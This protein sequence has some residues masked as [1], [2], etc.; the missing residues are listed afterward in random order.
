MI[1]TIFYFV[2]TEQEYQAKRNSGEIKPYTI[3]FVRD[4]RA[5]WK[6]GIRYSGFTEDEI[7]QIIE[8]ETEDINAA[9]ELIN[10]TIEEINQQVSDE[11]D[12]L[13]DVVDGL[14]SEIQDKVE[15]LFADSQWIQNNQP[16][17]LV[18]PYD[19]SWDNNIQAYLQRVGL[20]D[21]N[22]DSIVTKWSTIR[23]SLNSIQSDVNSIT[24]TGGALD[25]L[26][27]QITQEV[28]D[29]GDAITNLGNTYARITDVDGVKD[30]IE[31][32]YS[33]LKSGS[34]ADKTYAEIVAAGKNGLS[35]AISDLRTSVDSLGSTYVAQS[36]LTSSV[37]SA[38]SGIINAASGTYANTSMFSKIDTNSDDIAAIAT[39]VTGDSSQSTVAAKLNGMTASLVTTAN[40]DSAMAGL[41]AQ[42]KNTVGDAIAAT[43]FAKANEQGSTITLDADQINLQGQ[44]N[45]ENAVGNWI[46]TKG[47]KV[48]DVDGEIKTVLEDGNAT[49]SGDVIANSLTAGPNSGMHIVTTGDEIQFLNGDAVLGKFVAEGDGLQMYILNEQGQLYKINFSNWSSTTSSGT[50]YTDQLYNISTNASYPYISERT[51]V[52]QKTINGEYYSNQAGTAQASYGTSTS[53]GEYLEKTG[54]TAAIV[55]DP[56]NGRSTLY[57]VS[58]YKDVYFVDGIKQNGPNIYGTISRT[59]GNYTRTYFIKGGTTTGE[60][61]SY[62][63]YVSNQSDRTINDYT[64]MVFNNQQYYFVYTF[65]GTASSKEDLAFTGGT[66]SYVQESS[67]GGS[68]VNYTPY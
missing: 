30:V 19:M 6:N 68:I 7:K 67:T 43:I 63:I 16:Q 18:V 36:S 25:L 60:I 35:S 32:M 24:E 20:W 48:S 53:T 28:T 47:L 34:G 12:R 56:G 61:S 5:I 15:D 27:S 62:Q 29:R 65:Y 10:H 64:S 26:Q 11:K 8:L 33:G 58:F 55:Q 54:S 57:L 2:D 9:I 13:D 21:Y 49:F 1:N 51:K 39:K 38:I 37:D 46:T 44:T 14:D 41:S 31:W 17:G 23:Q 3:V 4:T 40:L 50:S 52:Y 45:F 59:E 22:D 66:V 42:A